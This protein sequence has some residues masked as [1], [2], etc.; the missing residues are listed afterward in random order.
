MCGYRTSVS[1]VGPS[2]REDEGAAAAGHEVERDR[3]HASEWEVPDEGD[4]IGGYDSK[5]G[6]TLVSKRMR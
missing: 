2:P 3:P 5:E 1:S 6:P 4:G